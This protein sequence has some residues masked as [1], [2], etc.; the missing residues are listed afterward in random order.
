MY[1]DSPSTLHQQSIDTPPP[2][3]NVARHDTRLIQASP[4][5]RRATEANPG[6][7]GQT[8]V[9]LIFDDIPNVSTYGVHAV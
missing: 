1:S 2:L 7:P 6:N 8:L 9:S 3:R 4:R 5:P